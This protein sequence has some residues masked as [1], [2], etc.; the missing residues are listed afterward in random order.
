MHFDDYGLAQPQ[1]MHSQELAELYSGA[2]AMLEE[3]EP[4]VIEE[5][6]DT[7]EIGLHWTSVSTTLDPDW[8]TRAALVMC[9]RGL[10]GERKPTGIYFPD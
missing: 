10:R 7:W 3:F 2:C 1:L 5:M 6:L 8:Y 4:E 9:L